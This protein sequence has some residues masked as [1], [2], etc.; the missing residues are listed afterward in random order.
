MKMAMDGAGDRRSGFPRL[1]DRRFWRR[2]KRGA[3]GAGHVGADRGGLVKLEATAAAAGGG[4]S[5]EVSTACVDGGV[6]TDGI[7]L[8]GGKEGEMGFDVSLD[9]CVFSVFFTLF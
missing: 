3:N 6:F 1:R 5:D 9:T 4:A 7:G 8:D 2:K